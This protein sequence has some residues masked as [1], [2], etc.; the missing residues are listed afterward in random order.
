MGEQAVQLAK[1]VHYSSAGTVEF[2]V[3]SKKNF[4]FLEMNTR[5]QVSVGTH[6]ASGCLTWSCEGLGVKNILAV[7]EQTFQSVRLSLM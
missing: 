7:Q 1:A 2:L 3:D 6:R 5:L 4:Y